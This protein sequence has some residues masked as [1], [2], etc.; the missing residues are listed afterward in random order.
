M[1]NEQLYQYIEFR[2]RT[3]YKHLYEYKNIPPDILYEKADDD[4]LSGDDYRMLC[5]SYKI[6]VAD[7]EAYF[8]SRV[9]VCRTEPL[10]GELKPAF[11]NLVGKKYSVQRR[12]EKWMIG[13][14]SYKTFQDGPIYLCV[15][16]DLFDLRIVGLSIG[17]YRSPELVE[18]ALEHI[19][20][21]PGE[22][23]TEVIL[24]SGQN[25]LYKK[26]E[27]A[28][29]IGKYKVCPS[30]S[31]KGE[32]G[33]NAI[34]IFFSKLKRRLGYYL[35][36]DWQEAV[37]WLERDLFLYNKKIIAKESGVKDGNNQ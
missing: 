12:N 4:I 34:S 18:T 37:F 1:K 28:K 9:P 13:V 29:I 20:I 24:H 25:S 16:L 7:Y 5:N 2:A 21:R 33:G 22:W 6:S 8:N 10:E 19:F 14:G 36:N 35:F 30:M 15:I 27:Y 17:G 31:S 26:I 23:H 32:I 3:K 11:P